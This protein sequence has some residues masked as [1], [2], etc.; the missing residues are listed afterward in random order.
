M[1]NYIDVGKIVST[2]AVKGELVLK[3]ALGKKSSFK[4]TTVVFIEE[5]KNSFL[6]YFVE[7]IKIKNESEVYLK[8][9]GV[10]TKEQAQKLN[11]KPVWLKEEDFK[12]LAAKSSPISLLGF[13]VINEGEELGEVLEVIE[14]PHQVLCRID[15]NG[16]EALIPV[17]EETLEKLDKKNKKLYVVLPDGLLDL[18]R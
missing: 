18:Y 4:G 17:H 5:K 2:F 6:P 15:L 1:E 14:Q 12:R 11:A 13:M 10:D 8:L 9:E 7:S 16:N 3:H